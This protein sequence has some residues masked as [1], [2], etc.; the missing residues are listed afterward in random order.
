MASGRQLVDSR[1][2]EHSVEDLRG[3]VPVV[4]EP[5]GVDP[6]HGLHAVAEVTCDGGDWGSLGEQGRGA[7]VAERVEREAA[8]CKA[9][10][11]ERRPPGGVVELV[12][13]QHRRSSAALEHRSVAGVALAEVPAHLERDRCGHDD[14]ADLLGLRRRERELTADA[15]ELPVDGHVSALEVKTIGGHAQ[16]LTDAQAGHPER[17]RSSE[18]IG[19]GGQDGQRLSARRHVLWAH[20]AVGLVGAGLGRA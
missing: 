11:A 12:P 15:L 18:R 10:A 2:S 20:A 3:D 1:R 16:H 13:A 8:R 7:E 4:A 5:V 9:G 14:R 17:D 19:G 6:A